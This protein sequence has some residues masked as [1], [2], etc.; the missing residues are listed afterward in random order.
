M[1][2]RPGKAIRLG[3]SSCLLGEEVR[4]DGGHKHD[5][6][7]TET[8]GQFFQWVP[9]CPEMEIGLGTPRESLRLERIAGSGR[10][11]APRS[12]ADHTEAMQ[13]W[14]G[15]RLEE[16]AGLDLHGYVLKK[17]SP[18]CGMERVRIYD[19]TGVA[20]RKGTGLFAAALLARFPTLP[21]EE[22]G[23]LHDMPIRENFIER[24]FAYARWRAFLEAAP[25]AKDLVAFHT[26]HKLTLLAHDEQTYRQMGRLVARPGGGKVREVLNQYGALLMQALK[27]HA[28]AR[29]HANVLFHLMGY[30]KRHLDSGDKAELT[31]QIENY[32]N[33]LVPLVV[34]IT[35]L[36]HHFRRHPLDWVIAQTYLDPYPA[37]LMLRNHV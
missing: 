13:R 24:V 17:D 4:F 28:T 7:L 23:R 32:R 8:F 26:Q 16:L 12:G 37:E 25:R 10:L 6:L 35:L 20:E 30:L 11:I 5:A 1:K 9:V 21:V 29:K 14:A 2:S 15:Q 31:R 33:Q 19:E 34:P 27:V 18:S 3:I 36:Q 22:E